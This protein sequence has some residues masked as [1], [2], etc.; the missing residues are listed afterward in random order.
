MAGRNEGSNELRKKGKKEEERQGGRNESKEKNP[1]VSLEKRKT[2]N[3][4]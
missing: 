3:N 4:Y 1:L 2:H